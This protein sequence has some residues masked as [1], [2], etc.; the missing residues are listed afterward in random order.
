MANIDN[1]KFPYSIGMIPFVY[2]VNES[3]DNHGDIPNFLNFTLD[4]DS[5]TGLMIQQKSLEVENYLTKA[6]KLGRKITG[7]MDEYDLGKSYS[8]DFIDFIL[9]HENRIK[10]KSILEIGCGTGYLLNKL[11]LLGANVIGIEPGE[12]EQQARSKYDLN[13]ITDFF[14]SNQISEKFDI[15]IFYN[16]LEHINDLEDFLIN[17]K[18][19]LKSG[20]KAYFAVPDCEQ[21]IESGD[22]SML[23]HEHYCYFTSRTLKNT[24]YKILKVQSEVEKSTYGSELYGIID[25][26]NINLDYEIKIADFGDANFE[27][28][29]KADTFKMSFRNFLLENL[30]ENLTIGIYVPSRIVNALALLIED[31]DLKKLKFYDDDK[32]VYNKYFPGFDIKI[33]N[34]QDLIK[35]PPKFLLI[36]SYSFS[37][38]IYNNIVDDLPQDTVILFYKDF[39]KGGKYESST[40]RI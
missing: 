36:M 28:L 11:K 39:I 10:D 15:I 22:I 32:N 1:Y 40:N 26:E 2:G 31:V 19:Q 29:K 6:Y 5:E 35:E 8:K 23:L 37:A 18:K 34:R 4:V 20:G 16:V 12:E 21:A 17:V 30:K 13:V 33:E 7:Y 14:P 38:Q 27:Y 24:I 25:F 3:I 9:C